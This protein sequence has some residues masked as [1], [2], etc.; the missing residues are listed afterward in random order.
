VQHV[1][2]P[3]L[4]KTGDVGKLVDQTGG[5]KEPSCSE[6]T[7]VG[8]RD[9]EALFVVGDARDF[10]RDDEA[11]VAANFRASSFEELGG[12]EAIVSEQAVYSFG[13]SVA[14]PPGVDD[15]DGAL[16]AGEEQ[17]AVQARCPSPDHHDVVGVEEVVAH[18]RTENGG[19]SSVS[20]PTYA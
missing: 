6:R 3:P 15:R 5:D 16:G 9:H 2:T 4:S 12:R 10:T 17:R 7:T 1:A 13:G 20:S 8:Q 14:R 18:D 19:Y 11:A